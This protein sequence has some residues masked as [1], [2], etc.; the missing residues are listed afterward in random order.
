MSQSENM[1]SVTVSSA[2]KFNGNNF[3]LWKMKILAYLQDKELVEV[4][5]QAA[6]EAAAALG[7]LAAVAAGVNAAEQ[8]AAK[9]EEENRIK[10]CMKAY[11]ILVLT[12]QDEQLQLVLDVARG[13]AHGVWKAL[14][15]RYERRTIASKTQ[16]RNML[17]QSKMGNDELVE[18]YISRIKR[19]VVSLSEMGSPTSNDELLQ[20]LFNGLPEAYE[21][22]VDSLT[23]YESLT[24]DEACVF[25]LDRQERINIKRGKI[26]QQE[27]EQASYAQARGDQSRSG[28]QN[29]RARGRGRGRYTQ[30]GS[31]AA[32]SAAGKRNRTCFTCEKPGHIA[33]YCHLNANAKK[34]ANCRIIGHATE[35]CYY[36]TGSTG[37]GTG[38]GHGNGT[39]H[40]MNTGMLATAAHE[41]E[42]CDVV[43]SASEHAYHVNITTPESWIVDTGATRHITNSKLGM[44]NIK[45][46]N[47]PIELTVANNEKVLLSEVGSAVVKV[48]NGQAGST[49]TGTGDGTIKLNEVS[50]A[51]TFK[52]NLMSVAKMVDTGA[53]V[54]FTKDKAV[55]TKN[56]KVLL[57]IPRQGNLFVIN[58]QPI[59]QST[60]ATY[61]AKE[62]SIATSTALSAATGSTRAVD[63][64]LWHHRMGHLSVSSLKK[65]KDGSAV[66]G[67]EAI[68]VHNDEH[69]C[70][71]CALGKAHRKPFQNYRS[72][73]AKDIMDC[74]H[75]DLCG[76]IKIKENKSGESVDENLSGKYTSSIIDEASRR[77]VMHIIN[78]KSEAAGKIMN[79][80][81][82]ATVL[83]GKPLKEFHS[84][85]GGE[86]VSNKLLTYF[87]NKGTM[88]TRT[89]KATPQLNGI[90][91]R[92]NR[93]IF[94]MAR[95]MLYHANLSKAFWEEAILTA[96]YIH[97]RTISVKSKNKTPEELFTGKKPHVKHLRV[98][99]CDCYMHVPDG[100]RT[101]LDKKSKRGIFVGYDAVQRGYKVYDYELK[102][103]IISR[104]V[105][106]NED[107]F[108]FGRSKQLLVNMDN[109]NNNNKHSNDIDDIDE[110]IG[111][112]D[113]TKINNI[114]II[115]GNPNINSV[116][117][118]DRDDAQHLP[119]DINI[120]INEHKYDND[121]E[122]APA[123]AEPLVPVAILPPVNN[124]VANNLPNMPV[125]GNNNNSRPRRNRRAP[126][127]EFMVNIDS[128]N[129]NNFS[130]LATTVEEP[131]TYQEMLVSQ[132]VYQWHEA[133]K[134][135]IKALYENNTWRLVQLPAG[136]TAI[137][138]KWVYKVK[139]NKDGGI[140]RYKARFCAKGYSQEQGID[141]NETFAPVVKYKSLRIILALVTINDYEL[142]QMDVHTAFLNATIK[143]E[144]Y[145]KQPE[146]FEK[147]GENIVCKLNKTLY[148][149]K[150]APH[151]WNEDFNSFTLT[152]G[153]KRCVS[154]TCVYVK[155]SKTGKPI[156][157][158]VFV[159]DIISA[160]AK[161]D[162]DE[163]YGYK[164]SFT[165]HYKMKDIGE[166]EWIL[167]MRVRR[168]RKKR[169]LILDQEQYINKVLKQF[170]MDNCKPAITPEDTSKLVVNQPEEQQHINIKTYQSLVGALMYAAISTRPDI[171]HAVNMISRHLSNPASSHLVAGKRILRYLKGTTSLGLTYRGEG[172]IN[173]IINVHAYTDADWAGDLE[174]RKS[175]TGYL[176]MINKC[177]VSWMSKKQ[178]TVALSTA[179]AE[180]M[181][182]SAAVQ[183][184]KWVRQLLDELSFTQSEPSLLLS[185]NQ[186]AIAIS[187]NDVHHNRTKHIDIRHH[188]VREQIKNKVIQLKW[189]P[190]DIQLADLL[191]KGLSKVKFTQLRN[192]CIN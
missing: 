132:D 114:N 2:L 94:E 162:Q 4:V 148:G 91:E 177:V 51:P 120:D 192:Q 184:I 181:A 61:I 88:A 189:V 87:R 130:A 178:N 23:V 33:Y 42:E 124:P 188:F 71:G 128:Y 20:I 105:L 8:K 70:D 73:E 101:K 145:M 7:E 74:V 108:T 168:D 171:T 107:R 12:L 17:T 68:V 190:S 139:L 62:T 77:I 46:L 118:A 47:S 38:N 169:I 186:A 159:D 82:E 136:R 104:D 191:T 123:P 57:E 122:P 156:I 116:A 48:S 15:Q 41:A 30:S 158:S 24:F 149:T 25:I 52:S 141:Y 127:R 154:D 170:G 146:G 67:S 137:G 92:A 131:K 29:R 35:D 126:E 99:G 138:S 109:N 63:N 26:K 185:D 150:Q 80:C 110:T 72:E 5:E 40:G 11:T 36:G 22:L 9:E 140:D 14:L 75:A 165:S 113:Y 112:L 179:E 58:P 39:G 89:V 147:G 3:S 27:E 172:D 45:K 160:Y 134:E 83:T 86:Y 97:N 180:Y 98:F 151:E 157:I 176:V 173:G 102:K 81:N 163:W 43:F 182:I 34:C 6:P 54:L 90:A 106:F 66:V 49:G 161:K 152:L 64:K 16:A 117:A 144:V 32:S 129:F 79:W 103:I 166:C 183:E 142:S 96:V 28:D 69:V 31:A 143:Q 1:Q 121:A 95:S 76:P 53:E 13:N 84:D 119:Q 50:Y 21:T 174:E 18:T 59:N 37:T 10:K 125:A 56:G 100:D 60:S 167:G 85:G 164:A 44:N 111:T 155:I 115:N 65:I 19:L 133:M 93:T 78:Y 153:F 55:V 135:E 187:E 175:T